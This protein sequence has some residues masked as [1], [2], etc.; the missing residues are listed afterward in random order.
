M[1]KSFLKIKFILADNHLIIED[2]VADND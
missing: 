1:L 2:A